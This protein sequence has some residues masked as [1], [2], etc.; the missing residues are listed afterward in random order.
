MGENL[1][2][3]CLKARYGIE[4]DPR[5][6]DDP[7]VNWSSYDAIIIRTAWDY[8][9]RLDDFKQ[10]M[11]QIEETGV[12]VFNDLAVIRWNIHKS[13]LKELELNGIRVPASEYFTQRSEDFPDLRKLMDSREWTQVVIK[14]C[15]GASAYKTTLVNSLSEVGQGQR[16]LED[17]LKERDAMV[18][19]YI[20]EITT[21]GEWSVIFFNRVF[22]HAMVKLPNPGD[23]KVNVDP[24][25]E[26]CNLP[27]EPPPSVKDAA[28][29]VMQQVKGT[30]STAVLT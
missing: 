25:S 22:S 17:L 28:E 5:P 7:K 11:K 9:L 3:E 30:C 26:A 27:R 14:P 13:Y 12:P 29:A 23:F 24:D 15:I 8:H 21:R 2:A 16:D 18:Q 19:E 10:W 20:A 6:W 1:A 4:T